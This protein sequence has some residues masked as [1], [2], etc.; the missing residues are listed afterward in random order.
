[1]KLN[2]NLNN[3]KSVLQECIVHTI[4]RS[5]KNHFEVLFA[6][7]QQCISRKSYLLTIPQITLTPGF[8]TDQGQDFT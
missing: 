7:E 6:F 5:L 4:V 3:C 1:M 8:H 2:W